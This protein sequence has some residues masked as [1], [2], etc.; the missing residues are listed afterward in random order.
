MFIIKFENGSYYSGGSFNYT[1]NEGRIHRVPAL[2]TEN[3]AKRF[4]RHDVAQ[5]IADTI[6]EYTVKEYPHATVM[7]V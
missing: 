1:D 5:K 4:S 2:Q 7:E 3:G 6:N